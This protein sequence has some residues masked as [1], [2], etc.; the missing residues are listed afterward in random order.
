[1][2]SARRFRAKCAGSAVDC[3][4]Y[5]EL[6]CLS[7][8]T[9]LRGASHPHELVEQAEALGYRRARTSPMSARW[10]AW[11]AR[12]WRRRS[13]PLKLIIGAELRLQLRTEVR[14]ARHRPARLWA[15]C[16]VSS[17]AAGGPPSKGQYTLTRADVTELGPEQCYILW[18]PAARPEA[19]RA[20]LAR[21]ALSRPGEDRGRAAARRGARRAARE[22]YAARC[23]AMACRSSPAA[24]CTCTCARA[25]ACRMRSPP[26]A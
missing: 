3:P 8:F 11:C 7:N 15:R 18:L 20:E 24:T 6:H 13:R 21:G 26:S 1:M 4:T 9:F 23:A 22:P 19:R 14:R 10:P 25:A 5:A 2:V 17:P 12:T 16:A